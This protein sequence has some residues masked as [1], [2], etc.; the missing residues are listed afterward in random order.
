VLTS[1][2]HGHERTAWQA[3][4]P[5]GEDELPASAL[6]VSGFAA[7]LYLCAVIVVALYLPIFEMG[8]RLK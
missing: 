6:E 3:E 7:W 5:E 2:P 4:A 1:H 8:A